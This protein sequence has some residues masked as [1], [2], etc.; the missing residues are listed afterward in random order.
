MLSLCIPRITRR[1]L[2]LLVCGCVQLR[3]DSCDKTSVRQKKPGRS[4]EECWM[5]SGM[6]VLLQ[7]KMLFVSARLLIPDMSGQST[8]WWGGNGVKLSEWSG[9]KNPWGQCSGPGSQG[10]WCNNTLKNVAY[11]N[12]WSAS[13]LPVW[14]KK[15]SDMVCKRSVCV[16]F[17]KSQL[18]YVFSFMY[19][20]AGVT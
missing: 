16:Y 18:Y 12:T 7:L 15:T 20:Q 3:R 6:H 14:C 4:A 17:T 1:L 13:E 9:A 10:K 19:N 8:A 11:K 2:Y 5:I